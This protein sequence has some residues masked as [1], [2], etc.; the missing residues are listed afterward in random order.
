MKNYDLLDEFLQQD[1]Y[2]RKFCLKLLEV[3]RQNKATWEA[4]RLAVLMLEHQILQLSPHNLFDF[5]F[6]LGELGLKAPGNSEISASVLKEGYSTTDLCGFISEFLRRLERLN[7][8]HSRIKG[9]RTP[10]T[11]VRDFI[12]LSRNDCKLT[13]GRYLFKP[14]EVV[15]EILRQL[16]VSDGVCDLSME[17]Y[18]FGKEDIARV[19]S[20][21]PDYE[22]GIL[23]RL[24]DASRIYWVSKNTSSQINSLVEYPLTTVVL[25][26]KPPGSNIEFEIKRAGLRGPNPLSVVYT[27]RRGYVLPPS[28]RL[29]GGNMLWLLQYEAAASRKLG[30]IYRLVHRTEPP[31]PYYVSRSNVYSV[32]AGKTEVQTLPYFTEPQLFGPGFQAMRAAM[33][34]SVRAFMREGN[35]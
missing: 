27:S 9:R 15:S 11:A 35:D 1:R 32:P 18:P 12:E 25:V 3:A 23:R 22:A 8:I 7:Y 34:D 30:A 14:Q 13:L 16:E 5:D 24:I 2:S 20:I 10:D 33:K 29:S 19:T 6:L 31:I 26:I 17:D 28:H 4:R 21:L